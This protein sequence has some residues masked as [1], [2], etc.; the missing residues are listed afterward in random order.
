MA[1]VEDERSNKH[2]SNR[3]EGAQRRRRHRG[4][5]KRVYGEE[6][7][8]IAAN[9]KTLTR[10]GVRAGEISSEKDEET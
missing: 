9:S 6:I 1:P 3:H 10:S 8:I 5:E 7:E 4:A 2:V